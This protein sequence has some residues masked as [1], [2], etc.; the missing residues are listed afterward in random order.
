MAFHP[1]PRSQP[2]GLNLTPMIDVT[3]QLLIFF[4]CANTWS[5]LASAERLDLPAPIQTARAPEIAERPQFIINLR[6]NGEIVVGTE[7][8]LSRERL[9]ELLK[10]DYRRHSEKLEVVIRAHKGVPYGR[11][12]EALQ[13]CRA[14]GIRQVRFAVLRRK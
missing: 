13:A 1:R 2:F 7:E 12:Q 4:V 10:A 14:A 5:H 6:A 3:F 11:T 9:T 8:N